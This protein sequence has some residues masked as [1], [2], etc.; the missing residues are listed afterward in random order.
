MFNKFVTEINKGVIEPEQNKV[1]IYTYYR[2][3]GS[4]SFFW[5][6]YL[7]SPLGG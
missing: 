5:Y 6:K 7:N 1:V 4:T 2:K 3:R